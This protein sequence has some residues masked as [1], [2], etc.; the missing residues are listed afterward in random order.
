MR[1]TIRPASPGDIPRIMEIRHAVR[2][3]VSPIRA[4]L[5]PPICAA[6]I[7]HS[8]I[9]V[10]VEDD[11]ILAFAAGDTRNGWIW[12]LFVDPG[13]EGRGIGQALLPLACDTLRN[14]GHTSA[15][16]STTAGIRAD[17]FYRRNGWTGIGTNEKGE[18]VFQKP[19]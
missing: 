10:W 7:E 9:W 2:E 12:A 6:F 16:L 8:D 5:P 1:K 18:I 15:T 17:R 14:G 13:H 19:I 3:T 11:L 4:S